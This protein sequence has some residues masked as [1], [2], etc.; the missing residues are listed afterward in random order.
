M[1]ANNNNND[2]FQY[3]NLSN[4]NLDVLPEIP[5]GTTMLSC[6]GNN[7]TL[8][9]A[10]PEGLEVLFCMNNKITELPPL[11]STLR[12]LD[13]NNNRIEALPAL[14]ATLDD[15]VCSRNPIP[16]L[17]PLPEGLVVLEVS[18][19]EIQTLPA[20]LPPRLEILSAS[21]T[22]IRTI[23]KLPQ[24]LQLIEFN[25]IELDEPYQTLYRRYMES[26]R[27]HPETGLPYGNI[28]EF[29]RGVNAAQEVAAA[30]AILRV[31]RSNYPQNVITLEPFE[32]GETVEVLYSQEQY[33]DL[34][35]G[36]RVNITPAMVMKKQSARELSMRSPDG[37]F[38]NPSTREWVVHRETKKLQFI[39]EAA[40]APAA[41]NALD[42]AGAGA[43]PGPGQKGGK[44]RR[45]R[46]NR[47]SKRKQTHRRRRA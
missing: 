28:K 2:D 24:T 12:K 15:L 18:S 43:G 4:K 39:D 3:L 37:R 21:R 29:I 22:N 47:K 6:Y 9:P 5:A 36:R 33:N 16:E 13:C 17:P 8:L 27:P 25:D 11:P 42:A 14:P 23:P 7:L 44:T 38:K 31:K 10:L 1:A 40:A 41:G 30:D 35:A 46:R 26:M 32:D 45:R 19:T 34:Q 20:N